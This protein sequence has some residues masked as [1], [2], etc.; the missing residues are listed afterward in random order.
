MK[1][2]HTSR[3]LILHQRALTFTGLL[4]P[5]GTV[6]DGQAIRPL[7]LCIDTVPS[8]SHSAPGGSVD[9][10]SETCLCTQVCW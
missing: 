5:C 10:A 8:L 3:L 2:V 1:S 6:W 9:K 4:G 7:T